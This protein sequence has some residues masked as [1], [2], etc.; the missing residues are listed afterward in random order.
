MGLRIKIKGDVYVNAKKKDFGLKLLD[1]AIYLNETEGYSL[2]TI[3]IVENT[4]YDCFIISLADLDNIC[5]HEH[6]SYNDSIDIVSKIHEISPHLIAVSVPEDIFIEN[7]ELLNEIPQI[8]LVSINENDPCSIL[9]ETYLCADLE[10][11]TD[12]LS[13][14]VDVLSE[15]KLSTVGKYLNRAGIGAGLVGAGKAAK[16]MHDS[17]K[18]GG[19]YGLEL[20]LFKNPNAV[21]DFAAAQN[22]VRVGAYLSLAGNTLKGIDWAGDKLAKVYQNYKDKPRN[23]IAKV[24]A[25]LRS[26]YFKLQEK[27]NKE[28]ESGKAKKYRKIM[29]KILNCI[30][31]LLLVMQRAVN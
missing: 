22:Y 4:Y 24:I 29:S 20:G 19:K 25:K 5:L 17:R 12:L 2:N 18:L 10:N 14:F 21:D 26:T 13:E 11:D 8:L 6:T 30:D 27:L 28:V 16:L 23:V 9:C 1:E 31:K 7:F 3:P 15:G